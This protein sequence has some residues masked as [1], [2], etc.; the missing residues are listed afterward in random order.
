MSTYLGLVQYHYSEFTVS[1]LSQLG[2]SLSICG[3]CVAV[4]PGT[5]HSVVI[6]HRVLI[7]LVEITAT[8]QPGKLT[9][10]INEAALWVIGGV[11]IGFLEL[12]VLIWD[13]LLTISTD[14][15]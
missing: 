14:G 4:D 11:K 15:V 3:L 7:V 13:F 2:S 5:L 10:N 1:H 12:D 8:Y 9:G 6:C